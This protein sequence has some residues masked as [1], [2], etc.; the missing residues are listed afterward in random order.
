[1]FSFFLA[2]VSLIQAASYDPA[3]SLCKPALARKAG[4][5]IA[6]IDVR[7][8]RSHRSS[9]IIEGELTA[10]VGMGPPASGSAATHHLIRSDFSFRCRIVRGR[11]KEVA[12]NPLT[13]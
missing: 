7:S 11:V 13:G 3:V 2:S 5:Q 12:V 8:R 1:M 6:T 4:G 10:F 9:R